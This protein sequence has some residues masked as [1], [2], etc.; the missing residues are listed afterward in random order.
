MESV[1][2]E[3]SIFA[4]LRPGSLRRVSGLR[5]NMAVYVRVCLL[6]FLWGKDRAESRKRR[7][8][9]SEPQTYRTTLRQAQGRPERKSKDG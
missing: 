6:S 1:R 7:F 8:S 2:G 3:I 4:S 5:G 9:V